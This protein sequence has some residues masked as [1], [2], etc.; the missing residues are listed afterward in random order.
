MPRIRSIKPEF[1]TDEKM[2]VVSRD[3]RLTFLLLVTQAD[4]DG[5]VRA[6]D[7]ELLGA[8]YPQDNTVTG[9]LVRE[10]VNELVAQGNVRW[11][12]TRGGSPVVELVNFPKHQKIDKKSK[13]KIR[14]LLEPIPG[15]PAEPDAEPPQQVELP[16][17]PV[18]EIPRETLARPSRDPRGEFPDGSG[19]GAGSL[20]FDQGGGAGSAPR[21]TAERVENSG[22]NAPGDERPAVIGAFVAEFYGGASEERQGDVRAQ[23]EALFTRAGCEFEGQRVFT[24]DLAHLRRCM[25]AVRNKPPTK[26]DA[27]IVL[28]LLKLRDS[29]TEAMSEVSKTAE[30]VRRRLAG[31]AP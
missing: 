27:A 10:W 16:L 2:N 4:D 24:A 21:T 20:K 29:Y 19:S 12:R 28:L 26:P 23:L 15:E 7:R 25:M 13:S 17:S 5:L 9:P 8:L 31:G 30:G 1:P 11:R 18:S 6:T 22:E 3:A 14:P